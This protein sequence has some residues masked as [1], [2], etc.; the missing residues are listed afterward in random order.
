MPTGARSVRRPQGRHSFIQ[1][2]FG[3]GDST[4][5]DIG[6]VK[7]TED[8]TAMKSMH[9]AVPFGIARCAPF[10][11]LAISVA[12]V[13]GGSPWIESVLACGNCGCCR[14]EPPGAVEVI[15]PTSPAAGTSDS[16][17]SGAGALPIEP[18]SWT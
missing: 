11:K 18:G 13:V 7:R 16:I 1:L 5:P 2:L 8:G 10:A 4:A 14:N 9:L 12:F 15:E 6:E 3:T 17:A